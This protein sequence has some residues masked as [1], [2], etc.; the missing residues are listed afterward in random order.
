MVV[1]ISR[2]KTGL[3]EN[4]PSLKVAT[5]SLNYSPQKKLFHKTKIDFQ[6]CSDLGLNPLLLASEVRNVQVDHDAS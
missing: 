6:G 2:G 1:H 3:D 5:Q 4:T